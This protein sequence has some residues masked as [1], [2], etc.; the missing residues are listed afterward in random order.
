MKQLIIGQNKAYASGV[1]YFDLTQL[2]E[3]VI[4]IFNPSTG[5]L[6]TSKE[7]LPTNFAIACGSGADK[8]PIE[9]NVSLKGFSVVKAE[10]S[11]GNVYQ[12]KFTIPTPVIGKDYTV[13]ITKKG[14]TFNERN[15]WTAT[16][17][18]KTENAEDVAEAIVK[19]INFN[20]INLGIKASNSGDEVTLEGVSM[21]QDY[22]VN[23]ADEM[24][25]QELDEEVSAKTP[26]LDKA[27][28]QNIASQCAAG[29]GFNDVYPDGHTIYKGYPENV[30]DVNYVMYTLRF[31]NPR[32]SHRTTDEP[33]YQ[34]LHIA[35]PED[36]SCVSTFDSIFDVESDG[37][38]AGSGENGGTG[39]VEGASILQEDCGHID[40][41]G[42]GS[43]DHL[44]P[45]K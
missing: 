36:A 31:F 43:V 42:D 26:I 5:V 16:L 38:S 45:D 4:G 12:C 44:T 14:V 29:K 35:V 17:R 2:E 18:A 20:T 24:M 19:Q 10:P 1:D 13:V 3:G 27:Y 8:Y 7:E 15:N 28:V 25:G 41:D 6:V 11:E 30:E 37:S 21:N 22:A 9:F 34:I 40:I 33:V 32:V 23:L 39:G